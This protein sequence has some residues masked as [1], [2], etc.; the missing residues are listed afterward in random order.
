MRFQMST[1]S[2]PPSREAPN[3]HLEVA[4]INKDMQ[5]SLRERAGGLFLLMVKSKNTVTIANE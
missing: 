2:R 3:P 5:G 1:I 4:T